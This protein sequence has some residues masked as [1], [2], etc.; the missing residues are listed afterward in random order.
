MSTKLTNKH[1]IRLYRGVEDPTPNQ[2]KTTYQPNV[3]DCYYLDYNTEE[4]KSDVFTIIQKGNHQILGDPFNI[5]DDSYIDDT[6]IF[7]ECYNDPDQVLVH[8]NINELIELENWI[9]KIYTDSQE[10]SKNILTDGKDGIIK[11]IELIDF[12][13]IIISWLAG[14]GINLSTG[15]DLEKILDHGMVKLNQIDH[16]PKFRTIKIRG[17]K[18]YLTKNQASIVKILFDNY[19]NGK[20]EMHQLDIIA[21][22]EKNVKK[23]LSSKQTRVRDIFVH[24]KNDQ[25][26]W[27]ELFSKVILPGNRRG[28][29]KLNLD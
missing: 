19:Q 29:L 5:E 9:K 20:T 25:E 14:Y 7:W 22:W 11:V 17:N 27:D 4:G 6:D 15:K 16:T 23:E 2:Y 8:L 24:N 26:I 21:E 1:E 3:P 10:F 18:Y 13:K 28:F 12:R